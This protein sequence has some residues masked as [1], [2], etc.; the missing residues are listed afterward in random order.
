MASGV[1]S[2]PASSDGA[3]TLP[4]LPRRQDVPAQRRDT[5]L[6]L[7]EAMIKVASKAAFLHGLLQ[8]QVRC[9]DDADIDVDFA[10]AAQPIVR[11]AVENSEQLDLYLGIEFSDFIE[12]ERAVV[13]HFKK[14][15][16]EIVGTAEGTLFM[17]RKA[18][19]RQ[20]CLEAR[21]S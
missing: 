11:Y 4:E 5:Q 18:H 15:R 2:A 21:H 19:S 17:P 8:I 20:G 1:K 12:E 16:L 9:R 14:T 10:T 13:G 3:G 7:V 6:K